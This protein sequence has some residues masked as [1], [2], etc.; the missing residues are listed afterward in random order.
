MS[1]IIITYVFDGQSKR[2]VSVDIGERETGT[3]G[4]ELVNDVRVVAH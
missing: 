3:T 4:E 2:R 1:P